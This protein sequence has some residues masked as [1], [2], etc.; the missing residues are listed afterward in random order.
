MIIFKNLK[1]TMHIVIKHSAYLRGL[2]SKGNIACTRRHP[3]RV[4]AKLSNNMG[5]FTNLSY[6]FLGGFEVPNR[7]LGVRNYVVFL[8]LN[9]SSSPVTSSGQKK[10]SPK[11]FMRRKQ[12][13]FAITRNLKGWGLRRVHSTNSSIGKGPSCVRSEENVLSGTY[14]SYQ[15]KIL[16]SNITNNKKLT[17]LSEIMADPNFLIAAWVRLKV[18][19]ENF[20]LRETNLSWFEETARQMRNGKFQ[21]SPSKRKDILKSNGKVLTMPSPRDKIIQEAMRFL[22]AL[23]FENDFSKN[24]YGWATGKGCHAALNQIKTEFSQDNWYIKVDIDQQFP[25]LDCH[26]LV[27]I[28]KTKIKDQAFI[29]LIYKYLRVGYSTTSKDESSMKIGTLR[30]RP[31]LPMLVNIYMIPFDNWVEVSLIPKYTKGERKKVNPQFAKMIDN[32]KVVDRSIPLLI[33]DNKT[34]LRLHYVRYADEFIMGLD[35]PK[36]YC[37]LIALECKTFL[38]KRLNLT[39]D[40]KKTE[41]THSQTDSVLFL[42][43][44]VHKAKLSKNKTA[45]NPQDIKTGNVTSTVLDAPINRVVEKLVTKGYANLNGSPTRNGRFINH[46]LFDIIEHYKMVER[47]ILQYYNLANNY[48]RVSVRIHYILKYS[49]ALTIASKMKLKTLKR[50]FNKYGKDIS[51]RDQKGKIKTSYPSIIYNRPKKPVRTLIFD[52]TTI[53]N[54]IDSFDN[55]IKRGRNDLKGPCVLCG[56]EKKIEI[57][58]VRKLSEGSKRKSYLSKMM[59]RMNRK[60]IPVCQKCHKAIHEGS[61]DGPNLRKP[62]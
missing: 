15:L 48:G 54:F 8:T 41:I 32:G 24:S 56:S 62:N 38:L 2:T 17:N 44:Q 31:I 20:I 26:I 51:I 4:G 30:G 3:G 12:T 14:E 61:Y 25:F 53:E 6:N 28:L 7:I 58:H 5:R 1:K 10:E 55:R 45:I 46:Q 42:G 22:L 50:V 47:S 23:V 34:Y 35:G 43:Y 60:Q 29:D 11:L 59:S 57:H 21:F 49:C 37:E 16:K 36:K 40:F 9:E 19:Q 39:L 27:N 13:E 52:Y 18:N 33:P